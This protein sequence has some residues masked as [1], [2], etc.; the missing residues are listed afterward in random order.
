MLLTV[1]GGIMRKFARKSSD[2]Y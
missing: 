1:E 2:N